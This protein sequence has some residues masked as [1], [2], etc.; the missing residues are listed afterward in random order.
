MGQRAASVCDC[1]VQVQPHHLTPSVKYTVEQVN[2]GKYWSNNNIIYQRHAHPVLRSPCQHLSF[3]LSAHYHH[4]IYLVIFKIQSWVVFIFILY[5]QNTFGKYLPITAYF[6][7]DIDT[8]TNYIVTYMHN[9][10]IGLK[11]CLYQ[12]S[13]C[14]CRE[15]C[16]ELWCWDQGLAADWSHL[17]YTPV[18]ALTQLPA[19]WTLLHQL[20]QHSSIPSNKQFNMAWND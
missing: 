8:S 10:T 13:I 9:K 12:Q 3:L 14:L 2:A 15:F 18:S 11:P 6:M 7:L 16:W 20:Q 5:F 17:P 19:T 4:F 1:P